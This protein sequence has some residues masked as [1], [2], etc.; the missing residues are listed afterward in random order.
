MDHLKNSSA[1]LLE[2]S[3]GSSQSVLLD[4]DSETY[5]MINLQQHIESVTSSDASY[6]DV[7]RELL[8]IY[9]DRL[10]IKNK[11]WSP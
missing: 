4:K 3:L 8:E 10:I 2:L 6:K 7:H 1:G 5:D 11:N 9:I